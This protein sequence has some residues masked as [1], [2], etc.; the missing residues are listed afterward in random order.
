M[1]NQIFDEDGK[2][3]KHPF[4]VF[5]HFLK[6]GVRATLKRFEEVQNP[7]QNLDQNSDS[8]ESSLTTALVFVFKGKRFLSLHLFSHN[9]QSY[10]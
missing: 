1:K 9:F 3:I 7:E 8:E 5:N 2:P 10:C 6:T 4:I